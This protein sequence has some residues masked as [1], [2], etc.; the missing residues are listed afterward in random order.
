M[1]ERR[2]RRVTILLLAAT[3]LGGDAAR[4]DGG[5]VSNRDRCHER[6]VGTDENVGPNVG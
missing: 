2:A 3:L 6:R 4:G 1:A 5:S